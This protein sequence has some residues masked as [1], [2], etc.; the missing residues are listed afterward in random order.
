[1]AIPLAA[2]VGGAGGISGLL[3]A[4]GMGA[5]QSGA[6]GANAAGAMTGSGGIMGGAGQGALASGPGGNEAQLM[7]DAPPSLGGMS[8]NKEKAGELGAAL[9]APAPPPQLAVN[10]VKGAPVLAGPTIPGISA[11][12]D[13]RIM[14]IM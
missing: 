1:M 14:G 6:L 9:M 3:Q 11:L 12:Q 5:G 2:A 4:L 8:L 10:P 13:P 7:K